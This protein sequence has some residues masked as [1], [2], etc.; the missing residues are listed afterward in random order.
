MANS[1]PSHPLIRRRS[2]ARKPPQNSI[3]ALA[4]DLTRTLE[5]RMSA[6]GSRPAS[7]TVTPNI[8][9]R[10]GEEIPEDEKRA[11]AA[12]LGV[13]SQQEELVREMRQEML[14]LEKKVREPLIVSSI[15]SLT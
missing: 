6:T 8:G 1:A 3:R 4:S 5:R 9:M 15:T 2:S 11:L 14:A 13:Q 12:L 7:G 10:D